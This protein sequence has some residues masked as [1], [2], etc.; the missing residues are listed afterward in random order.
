M[1][2]M[3][4]IADEGSLQCP[5]WWHKGLKGAILDWIVPHGQS[6][7]PSIVQNV[8]IDQGFN[9]EHTGALLCPVDMDWSDLEWVS[10]FQC[11]TVLACSGVAVLNP[12]FRMV[13]SWLQAISGLFFFTQISP[14]VQSIKLWRQQGQAMLKYMVWPK[15]LKLPFHMLPHRYVLWYQLIQPWPLPSVTKILS[16]IFQVQFAI[17]SSSIF[18]RADLTTDSEWFYDSILKLLKDIDEQQGRWQLT[19]MVEYVTHET[20]CIW[21]SEGSMLHKQAHISKPHLWTL[22]P[23]EE[24]C[25]QKDSREIGKI[26]SSFGINKC[27]S[28]LFFLIR[29]HY[30]NDASS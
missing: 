2:H 30:I 26:E 20:V 6:L 14:P 17:S 12:S 10:H 29:I 9:H 5:I 22:F 21:F 15:S 18:S 24:F 11:V 7:Y 27:K 25:T 23:E 19:E 8:K 1:T 16:L 3:S 13:R 28:S 4:L